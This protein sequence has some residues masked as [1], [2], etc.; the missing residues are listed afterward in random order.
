MNQKIRILLPLVFASALVGLLYAE[1]E[2][3]PFVQ[4]VRNLLLRTR[5]ESNAQSSS[6]PRR[7]SQKYKPSE[8]LVKFRETAGE[9]IKTYT[10]SSAG[11]KLLQNINHNG[12]SQIALPEGKSVED[13]VL[14]Y[15]QNSDV[16]YVQPNY[17]YRAKVAPNDNDYGK[18]WGLSNTAQTYL[19][20]T[21]P[22]AYTVNNPG[23]VGSDMDAENAWDVTHSC[24]N[25]IVAVLDSGVNYNHDD[26]AANIWDGAGC[27]SDT[28]SPASCPNGGWDFVSNDN[29]PMD[30]NG[31]GTHVSGTIAAVG[32][33]TIGTTGLCWTAKLMGV[34]ILDEW[35]AG[36][37]VDIIK[38]INF[39]A[40]N[41]AKV[42]NMS[43]GGPDYDQ[44]MRSAIAS[45]GSNYDVLFVVAAGNENSDLNF[46]DSYPCEYPEANILCVAALDQAFAKPNFSNYDSSQV[47]VD[48]GAPGTN[49]LSTWAGLEVSD[50]T[51]FNTWTR[52]PSANTNANWRVDN[53]CVS[54][55]SALYLSTSCSAGAAGT[56][57]NGYSNN[58]SATA[59]KTYTYPSGMDQVRADFYVFLDTEAG[60]DV[61]AVNN[62]N[63][64]GLPSFSG[65]VLGRY[66]GEMN[67]DYGYLSYH[68]TNC[69][70]SSTN[71][72][73]GFRF[74]SN[75]S[76]AKAGIV[77]AGFSFSA[78]DVDTTDRYNLIMGTSMA[79]PHVAGL[80]ALLRSYNPK[81]TYQDTID[82]IV[83]GGRTVSSL[84]GITK[85]GIAADANGALRYLKAP[86]NLSLIV[87]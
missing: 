56:A 79:T 69:T 15:S 77:I 83:S 45:A 58:V 21:Y 81:F 9:S 61:L 51:D 53:L 71:C 72:S 11:G 38:G 40:R 35:G 68:L 7:I 5:S 13:A 2:E 43:F 70:G 49:I 63:S 32:S 8:I 74:T 78:L 47:S 65:T 42:I 10:V 29:S 55:Y 23:G 31:H 34:R 52:N 22:E 75:A 84:Q 44:A 24:T 85:Y 76:I 59:Y 87:P 20:V 73:F 50:T 16:E 18:L 60:L 62:S 14:E 1:S 67:G 54:G 27:V 28:G 46:E 64:A 3:F 57:T 4:D 39:A 41:G 26:L 82:A 17:I 25:T 80:G 30:M 48:L 6:G 33:N 12:L 37:T 86:K 66:A 19:T 36:S